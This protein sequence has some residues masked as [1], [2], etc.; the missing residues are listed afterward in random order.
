ML[1]ST[2]VDSRVLGII[3]MGGLRNNEYIKDLQTF[4]TNESNEKIRF[5]A[6]ISL[7]VIGT[8]EALEVLG[9]FLL[10]GD[11]RS[12][13]FASQALALHPGEG[14]PMLKEVLGMDDVRVRRAAIFGLARV[15][16]DEIIPIL[17]KVQLEDNQAIVKNAATD[18]LENRQ[19]PKV[20]LSFPAEDIASLSWLIAYAADAGLGVMPG[21][22]ALEMLRRVFVNGNQLQ[23]IAALEA[24]GYFHAS[25]LTLETTQAIKDTDPLIRH[26]AYEALWRLYACKTLI[27]TEAEQIPTPS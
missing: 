18:V 27:G 10:S 24:V 1:Q 19:S 15:Q 20:R 4:I 2:S 23:K 17:E 6:C 13:V 14:V 5:A 7:A 11:D 25:D 9:K 3:G 8:T 22:G 12:Q 16:S 26:A 21:K